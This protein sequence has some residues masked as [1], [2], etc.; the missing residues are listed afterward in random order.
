[1]MRKIEHQEWRQ[2][3]PEHTPTLYESMPRQIATVIQAQV[4]HIGY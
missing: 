1:M 3:I 2:I 4:G